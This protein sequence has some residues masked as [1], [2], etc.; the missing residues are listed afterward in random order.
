MALN[1]YLLVADLAI[2]P[3]DG[4]NRVRAYALPSLVRLNAAFRAR[5]GHDLV[6]NEGYRDY[7]TQEKYYKNP[8]SGPGTAA[9]PG[10]SNHGW[11]L[12]VDLKLTSTEYAWMLANAPG[13]GWVNPPWARDDNPA[14]GAKE[15]WHWEHVGAPTVIP[16]QVTQTS[17]KEEEEEMTN[18]RLIRHPN[19]SI[20]VVDGPTMTVLTSGDEV[21]ALR[22]TGQVKDFSAES[23]W[24]QLPDGFA[25][26]LMARISAR[27]SAAFSTDPVAVA[28][29][30]AP[31][32]VPAVVQ[33]LADDPNT[34]G[35]TEEQVQA[36]AER[37]VRAVLGSL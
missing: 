29:A 24:Q 31:L 3:W 27:H 36:A 20:A 17:K 22:M 25:W 8:P 35:L 28:T 2:I 18:A 7:A 11:G 5:F 37:A 34:P 14:N 30:L 13:F 21:N 9:K 10:T 12:A 19:G 1:G 16:E 33:A 15:P 26:N 6:V 4:R 32:L 23:A